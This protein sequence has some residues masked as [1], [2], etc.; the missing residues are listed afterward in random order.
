MTLLR[1]FPLLLA[2]VLLLCT[3][4]DELAGPQKRQGARPLERSPMRLLDQVPANLTYRSGATWAGGTV[5]YLGTRLEPPNAHGGQTVRLSHYF[6]AMA[7]PPQG[8]RFFAH[9]IEPSTGAMVVNA[10][11]EI[12]GGALP[13]GR[14][15]VGKVVEDVHTVTLP[16][17]DAQLRV[18]LGF[19]QGETRLPVDESAAHDGR[20]RMLGPPLDGAGPALP[21]YHAPRTSHPPRIDGVLDD[22]AWREAPAVELVASNDGHRPSLK[23][24]ARLTYDSTNLYVGFECEDPDVWGTLLKHDDPIY[25]EE[26]VEIFIDADG[27]G[28]TYNELQVSPNNVTFDASFVTRRS[29]LATAMAWES[30]MKTA[31][32][33]RGTL[34]DPS[35]RD[36]GWSAEMQIP[37]AALTAV[38]QLPPQK[39]ARWRVNLYR[40]EHLQRTQVEGQ[41]F[42]PV[43]VGDFHHLPRFGWLQLD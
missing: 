34:N 4:R 43:F 19:W 26:V 41:A 18:A 1:P 20:N 11:H 22:V 6:R 3:C 2:A 42:S 23:T 39:G 29:D 27:D 36:E 12:Q 14:W 25:N 33:V 24:L 9:V 40:L 10:D 35:D 7:P 5:Q 28:K 15:P 31:V 32:K 17:T 38:P 13:L 37:L 8:Y 30:G 21:E 16:P